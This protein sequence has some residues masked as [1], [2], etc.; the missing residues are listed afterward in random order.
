VISTRHRH[1]TLGLLA[2]LAV[3]TYLDRVCISVAGPRLQD[4]LHLGPEQWGLVTGAFALAYLL[5][6]LPGGYLADRFGARAMVSRIV[7]WWSAFTAL[8][9]VASSLGSLV[10]IRFLFGAGEAGTYPTIG[11]SIFRWFPRVERGRAFGI[12][13]FASQLG[14]AIAPLVIVPLQQQFGWR[15][16]FYVFG[17]VG[18][19]WTWVWWRG[20]RNCPS[21]SHGIDAAEIAKI[22][23]DDDSHVHDFPW[24]VLVR[25]RHV[26]A[27]MG[28][29][30]GYAIP[31]YFFVFWLPTYMVRSRGFLESETRFSAL[32]FVLAA[33]A[34]L[35]GGYARDAAVRRWGPTPGPRLVCQSALIIA[36]AAALAGL[37]IP[38]RYG[39]LAALAVCYAAIAFQQ[40]TV[41]SSCV[42]MGRRYAGAVTGC[43][44]SS[45]ALGG[46]L[47]SAVFGFL[48]Q[49]FGNYDAVLAT[50]AA[51]LLV[52]A[53]FWQLIDAA[54]PVAVG[55]PGSG[56]AI[57]RAA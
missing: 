54:K 36:A 46:L 2:S 26:W 24:R 51:A 45:F 25:S 4:D 18:A 56:L 9:G 57:A 8:T 52:G 20:Y 30:F 6:E 12:I 50:M 16:T 53:A 35:A 43:M 7:L 21:E 10:V 49:H 40:P 17:G 33:A 13:F 42:E 23:G 47:S 44:N 14:G 41:L 37:Y 27:I 1:R 32:P 38:N 55:I 5:F 29:V 3:L 31:Y 22:G 15:T 48:V 39:A 19:L 28:A 34:G 11:T